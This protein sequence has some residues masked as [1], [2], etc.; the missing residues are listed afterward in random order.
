MIESQWFYS[1]K[2]TKVIEEMRLLF[3]LEASLLFFRLFSF[4]SADGSTPFFSAR[5]NSISLRQI[6]S[7]GET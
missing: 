6:N 4:L 1:R 3:L 7:P 2:S 5:G